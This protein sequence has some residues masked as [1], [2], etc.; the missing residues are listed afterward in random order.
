MAKAKQFDDERCKTCRHWRRIDERKGECLRYA[1][2]PATMGEMEMSTRSD[3]CD[4]RWPVTFALAC[5]GEWEV[6][7]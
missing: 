3:A 5:C 1:P 4:A 6:T 2:S 7:R